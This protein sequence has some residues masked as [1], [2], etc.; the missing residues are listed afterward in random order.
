MDYETTQQSLVEFQPNLSASN[1]LAVF[2][3]TFQEEAA[4]MLML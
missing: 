3:H 4:T 2:P 1:S